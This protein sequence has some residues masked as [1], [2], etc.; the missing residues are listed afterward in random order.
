[1]PTPRKLTV[2]DPA[3][4]PPKVAGVRLAQRLDRVEG[5][6]VYLVDCGFEDADRF[7]EQMQNWFVQH[8]P[9]VRTRTVHWRGHGFQPD[10][11][12]LAEVA[13]DG[14]AAILGVGI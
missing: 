11:Q 1:M 7:F 2:F 12:T 6:L 5:K 13:A 8:M 9:A 3:G 4:H 10:P 14:D